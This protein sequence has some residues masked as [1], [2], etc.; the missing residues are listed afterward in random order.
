MST[1]TLRKQGNSVGLT[2]PADTRTRLGLEVGQS[3]TV[4]E[5]SDGI[6]LVPYNPELERQLEHCP[7]GAG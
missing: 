3:M 4:V 1:V 7:Q 5:L 6:K 2:L